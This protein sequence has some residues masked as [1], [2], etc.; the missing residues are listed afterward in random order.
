MNEPRYRD[1]FRA[2]LKSFDRLTDRAALSVTPAKLELIAL[3]RGMTLEEFD[4]RYPSTVPLE[5]IALIN[6][7]APGDRLTAGTKVKRV[8]GGELPD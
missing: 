4:R 2:A 8:T 5:T 7:R 1:T 3:D 6:G